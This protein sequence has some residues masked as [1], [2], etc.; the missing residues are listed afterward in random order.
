MNEAAREAA[1]AIVVVD[2]SFF[3]AVLHLPPELALSVEEGQ[4]AFV[5][6]AAYPP[7]E[8][9][10]VGFSDGNFAPGRVWSV[11]P[12]I[13]RDRRSVIVRLRVQ[14]PHRLLRDGAHVT[15]WI[16]A[17]QAAQ[18]PAV[19]YGSLL[20]EGEDLFTFVFDPYSEVVHRR[21]VELGLL[22]LAQAQ[23]KVG[24]QDGDLLVVSG[25]QLL[26]DGDQVEALVAGGGKTNGAH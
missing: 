24:L 20:G 19:G 8:A 10:K 18:V 23:V 2:D 14:D 3:Y 12:A 21:R 17:R 26:A 9:E 7:I 4:P 16:A 25:Q 6:Y 13:T 22:G 5:S 1:A 11:R 15:A